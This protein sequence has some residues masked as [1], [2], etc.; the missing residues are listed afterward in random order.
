MN[1]LFPSAK[2]L[3][4]EAGL[5][6]LTDPLYAILV[7]TRSY[8]LS[9]AHTSLADV[10]EGAFLVSSQVLTGRT[11]VN[12]V[13]DA[14]DLGFS[15]YTGAPATALLLV[16]DGGTAHQSKL[17]AYFDTLAGLPYVPD[18]KQITVTW[19]DGPARIFSL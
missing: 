16:K 6:W 13:A 2:Q 9:P 15:P 19:D 17:I 4:L 10:D 11:S 3:F 18:G 5:N 14:D 12:G 7:D 1:I 8:V